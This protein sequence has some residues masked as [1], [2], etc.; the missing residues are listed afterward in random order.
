MVKRKYYLFYDK[1]E[2]EVLESFCYEL[3]GL[4]CSSLLKLL[5]PG[6]HL[7]VIHISEAV[8]KPSGS[9]WGKI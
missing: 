4:L 8:P 9:F 7:K 5:I 2:K 6:V 3:S 1:T